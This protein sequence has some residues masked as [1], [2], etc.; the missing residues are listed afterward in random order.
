MNV[1]VVLAEP[2]PVARAALTVL[3]AEHGGLELFATGEL[4]EALRAVARHRAPLLFVSRALLERDSAGL[5]LPAP[6]PAATRTI[7]LGLEDDAAF[8]LDARRAGAAAYVVKD[9]AAD[10]ELRSKV[11]ALLADRTL[12]MPLRLLG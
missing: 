11:D 4:G 7:V 12:T 6:L 10:G 2:H 5:R 8:A 3:L 9:R 1:P